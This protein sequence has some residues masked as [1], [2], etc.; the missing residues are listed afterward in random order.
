MPDTFEMLKDDGYIVA[1]LCVNVMILTSKIYINRIKIIRQ[2]FK[3]MN[4]DL[5]IMDL[6]YDRNKNKLNGKLQLEDLI[7]V[8]YIR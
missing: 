3:R 5:Y 1:Y 8:G 4:L 7:K 6:F 2:N